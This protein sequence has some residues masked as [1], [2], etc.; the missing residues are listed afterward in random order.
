MVRYWQA[1]RLRTPVRIIILF[2]P[3]VG[4]NETARVCWYFGNLTRSH[5]DIKSFG[6]IRWRSDIGTESRFTRRLRPPH[7]ALHRLV[8]RIE[9][10]NTQRAQCT[11]CSSHHTLPPPAEA[12]GEGRG[13]EGVGSYAALSV[14]HPVDTRN[15]SLRHNPRTN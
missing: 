10:R 2:N 11:A 7:S 4:R 14:P 12:R 8:C 15:C 13:I 6:F 3:F 9:L 5:S 1:S